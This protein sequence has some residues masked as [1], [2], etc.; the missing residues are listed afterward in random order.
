MADAFA[1][2]YV[3]VVDLAIPR[4][5]LQQFTVKHNALLCVLASARLHNAAE[6]IPDLQRRIDSIAMLKEQAEERYR[7][8]RERLKTV[9]G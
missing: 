2:E 1:D 7:A 8:A 9:G 4:S 5:I 6:V 3:R